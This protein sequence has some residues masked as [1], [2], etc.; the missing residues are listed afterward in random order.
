M[1][2]D[3]ECMQVAIRQSE[4][5]KCKKAKHGAVLVEGND[6]L[7]MGCNY[8]PDP[9]ECV[10]MNANHCSDYNGCPSTHAE[11]QAI[12]HATYFHN[13]SASLNSHLTRATLYVTGIPCMNCAKLI[14][15]MWIRYIVILIPERSLSNEEMSSLI[16]LG[17]YMFDVKFMRRNEVE[18]D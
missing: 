4:L 10:R 2:N 15:E 14:T 13:T 9:H 5:S 17:K 3:K 6:I 16:Y 18:G 1:M 12:S 11:V 7:G 8:F